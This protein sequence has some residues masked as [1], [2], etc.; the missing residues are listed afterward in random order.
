M[1]NLEEIYG[2]YEN[3]PSSEYTM[4]YSG[5]SAVFSALNDRV[6]YGVVEATFII[7]LIIVIMYLVFEKPVETWLVI[8][9]TLAGAAYAGLEFYQV[10]Q[11]TQK[12]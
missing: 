11:R 2:A 10:W 6:W 4:G 7:L 12:P 3:A 5:G 1:S 9:T 8:A